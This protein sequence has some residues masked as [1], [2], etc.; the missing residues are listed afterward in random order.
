MHALHSILAGIM[1]WPILFAVAASSQAPGIS[2]HTNEKEQTCRLAGMVV[3]AADGAPLKSATVRLENGE[4]RE[5]TIATKTAADGRY[6]LRNV[7]AGR[8]KLMV[9][10][11]GYVQQ[12][13]GQRKPSDP[14]A[15]FTLSPGQT[16]TDVVF[17]LLPSAVISGRVFDA[18]GEPVTGAW[19]RASRETYHE[20]QKTIG[21]FAQATSD[22]L[23]AFRLFGLAPGR[24]FVSAIE[25]RW[26]QTVG[27]KEFSGSAGNSGSEQGYARTYY[28]GTAD[29]TRAAAITVKAGDEIP[30]MDIALKQV[31]V[32]RIRGKVL[33]EV[34]HK[35]GQ[36]VNILLMPRT[37]RQEWDFAGDAQVKKADGSFEIAGVVPGPYTIFARWFDEEEGKDHIAMQS[38]EVGESDVESLFLTVGTGAT[39]QGRVQWDGK[40]SLDRDELSVYANPADMMFHGGTAARVDSKQQFTLKNLAAA[41]M[42][43]QVFG[44]SKDCYIKQIT[45]GQAFVKDDVISVAKGGNPALEI[46]VSSRG[47]RVQGSVTD[48]DGLPAPGVWAVAVPDGARRS[49]LRLF[50]SQTTDQYGKFD[51][52]GL[53]PG[54]YRIFAWDGIENNA[55]EDEDFLKPF[56]GQG[57]KIEV[58]DDD[59]R[60]V[61]LIAIAVKETGKN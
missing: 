4:D 10:R 27:D 41:D 18:D 42:R 23:G 48:K 13:F 34:T 6:E 38:I 1:A 50:N 2:K 24:Y 54:E 32:H 55:W 39:V 61:N 37:K 60:T 58:H 14:G 33:N 56:E 29:I 40:P 16:K 31:T 22:D 11:N 7:P 36:D 17:K 49:I 19:V 3:R 44:V 28:P 21:L 30:S 52:H 25:L 26:G 46:T 20:G 57:T 45:Y 5:H 12:E 15:T 43:V 35:H 53:A 47:A 59:A 51:L 8:Y 9:S